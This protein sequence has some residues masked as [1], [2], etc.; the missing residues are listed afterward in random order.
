MTFSLPSRTLIFWVKLQVIA[1]V[2]GRWSSIKNILHIL[3]FYIESYRYINESWFAI[4]F[5]SGGSQLLPSFSPELMTFFGLELMA[6]K[7]SMEK[8]TMS[9]PPTWKFC[10]IANV[11]ELRLELW[12]MLLCEFNLIQKWRRW[13]KVANHIKRKPNSEFPG[14]AFATRK[15]AGGSRRQWKR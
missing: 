7:L 5:L 14:P 9:I 15:A 11:V 10:F 2:T 6:S 3:N 13:E 1:I 12:S 8:K 4:P